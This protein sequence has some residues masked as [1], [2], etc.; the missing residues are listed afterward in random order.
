MLVKKACENRR[1]CCVCTDFA[2][3]LTP[4]S[5]VFC[6]TGQQKQKGLTDATAP[7][8]PGSAYLPE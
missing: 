2:S 3:K 4:I 7:V 1:I 8:R 5:K 6:E